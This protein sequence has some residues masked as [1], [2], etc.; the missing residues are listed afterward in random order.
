[1]PKLLSN[2]PIK[3]LTAETDYLGI[4]DKANLI[5]IFL[6]ANTEGFS[7]IK[8]FALYGEWGSGKSTLMKYL[9]KE[10]KTS[11]N[12]YFF[13]AWEF[14]SDSNLSLSLL[15]YLIK[16]TK[17]V[18]EQVSEEILDIAE[19]L[20]RGFTKSIR[21][22]IPGLS[23]DG[24]QIVEALEGEKEKSFLEL[25]E[26]FKT[27][28][29]RWE[30]FVTKRDAP[31]YNIVFIDD[32]DRCEPENVLNL[33]SAIKLLFSYGKKTIFFFGI[34][35]EAVRAAVKTKYG[36]VL[37][38]DEYLEKIFDISF[39]M[40]RDH[41]ISKL[42]RCYFPSLTIEHKEIKQK[43][44]EAITNF[45]KELKFDNPRRIKKVLN[46]YVL[47]TRVKKIVKEQTYSKSIPNIFIGEVDKSSF[48]ETV[49]VLYFII[50]EE[51]YSE[52]SNSIFDLKKK[53]SRYEEGLKHVF[54][55]EEDWVVKSGLEYIGDFFNS[56]TLKTPLNKLSINYCKDDL[57]AGTNLSGNIAGKN[58]RK[59]GAFYVCLGPVDVIKIKGSS[60]VHLDWMEDLIP[61]RKSID[62]LFF[63]YILSN[64]I[65]VSQCERL[66]S[67]SLLEIKSMVSKLL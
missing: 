44:D 58:R 15:E 37:K 48:F 41:E 9:E 50:I 8:M 29:V 16:K 18:E 11:F 31:K 12:T 35:K 28:F 42:V 51:F 40:P 49:L 19:K 34:D 32:L 36:E 21:L 23:I 54:S 57:V 62:Y 20:L 47:L 6:E 43:W 2:L 65:I 60:L 25:K 26:E 63:K 61:M 5:K 59:L 3:N 66:S 13:E 1:M 33:L 4:I 22:S 67:L 52:L 64:Q 27:E 53:K 39:S 38:A 7:E 56:N 14:E 55:H 30:D 24:K 17:L 46:K 10:L 45:F